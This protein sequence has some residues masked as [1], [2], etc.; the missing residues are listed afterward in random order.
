M[1]AVG[2]SRL[3][4]K[5]DLCADYLA[6]IAQLTSGNM[7]P[8]LALQQKHKLGDKLAINAARPYFN[9][10]DNTVDLDTLDVRDGIA[11]PADQDGVVLD[12]DLADR[13][14]ITIVIGLLN[15]HAEVWNACVAVENNA[16][17]VLT[18]DTTAVGGTTYAAVTISAN[19]LLGLELRGAADRI[20]ICFVGSSGGDGPALI[21]VYV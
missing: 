13:D 8:G 16:G 9:E 17:V 11:L 1:P 12:V 18:T 5:L 15:A 2:A 20:Y 14:E 7:D 6:R 19:Q 10:T 3:G 21:R 4:G